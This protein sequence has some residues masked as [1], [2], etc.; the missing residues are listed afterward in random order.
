MAKTKKTNTQNTITT[1]PSPY[2]SIKICKYDW[3]TIAF[4][5]NLFWYVYVNMTQALLKDIVAF[6]NG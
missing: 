4:I 3:G 6:G 1:F 2:W 5:A